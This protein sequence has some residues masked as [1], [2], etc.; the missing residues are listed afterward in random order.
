MLWGMLTLRIIWPKCSTAQRTTS[1]WTWTAQ[2]L[3]MV[4]SLTSRC[5]KESLHKIFFFFSQW[6]KI[7]LGRN[8][9]WMISFASQFENYFLGVIYK[10][11]AFSLCL[12][13]CLFLKKTSPQIVSSIT[14]C[15]ACGDNCTLPLSDWCVCDINKCSRQNCHCKWSFKT[16]VR[17]ERGQ[18]WKPC[19]FDRATNHAA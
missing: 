13:G 8:I 11:I 3:S 18:K 1:G 12:P 2:I 5:A 19:A 10:S 7:L 4:Q 15:L 9:L 6:I 14:S 17:R 16:F